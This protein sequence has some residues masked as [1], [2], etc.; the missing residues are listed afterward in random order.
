MR[1]Q[2]EK[3][4]DLG[5]D[6]RDCDRVALPTTSNKGKEPT[7]SDD[8]DTP[9]DNELSS[10]NSPSLSLSPTKN[11]REG[12]KAKSHKR[13]SHHPAFSNAISGTSRRARREIS[14]R[15][16][17]PVQGLGNTSVLPEGTMAPVLPA[18]MM[19]QMP[20]VHPAFG[21]GPTFSMPPATLIHRPDDILSLSLGQHILD[22]EPPHG[23]VIPAFTTID[24]SEDPYDH[25]LHYNQTMVRNAS[26][27]CLLCKV[28]SASLCGSAFAWFHK[29]SHNSINMFHEPWAT[30][31]SQYLC[32]M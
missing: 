10:G 20:F 25:M 12:A 21:A 2:I 31:V 3:S 23:F 8:A 27:D 28:F 15:K 30:F 17:Q 7:V 24:A 19:P 13:P 5:K 26:N 29:L 32:S 14:G 22:Y 1:S 9:A 11:A 4:R 18:G 16:N 6:V